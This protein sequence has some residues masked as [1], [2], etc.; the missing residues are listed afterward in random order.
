MRRR[1][2]VTPRPQYDRAPPRRPGEPPRSEAWRR[3]SARIAELERE[4]GA[5]EADAA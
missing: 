1:D 5:D 3:E 4:A 2:A